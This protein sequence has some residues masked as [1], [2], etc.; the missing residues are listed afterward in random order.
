MLQFKDKKVLVT[1]GSRGIGESIAVAF[2]RSGARVAINYRANEKAAASCV[3]KLTGKG[4]IALQ[5]DIADPA[6]AAALV[7]QAIEGLGGL[8]IVVNNAGIW[9]SH[10]IASVTYSEW[11][12]AWRQT[13]DTNL[14]AVSSICYCAAQ[15]M[16]RNGGG[17]IVNVSSRGAFRGEPEGPAY[18]ASKA[19]LNSL[20]Q[21]LAVALAPHNIFVGVVAPGFVETEMA[22][23]WLDGKLGDAIRAQS[24]L[25]RVARPEE[26]AHAVLFL[27]SEGAEFTTGTIIDVNG[28]SYLRS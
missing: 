8:N 12:A 5:A 21:S 7:E 11:N 24:P 18:G 6:Q 4:H 26:V 15:H 14:I 19:G 13:I 1:G 28:A 27:A 9:L 25:G 16:M 20:S 22:A 10:P 3:R 23:E 2:A 17:R